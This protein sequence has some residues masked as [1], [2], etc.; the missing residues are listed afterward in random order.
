VNHPRRDLSLLPFVGLRLLGRLELVSNGRAPTLKAGGAFD[1]GGLILW[2]RALAANASASSNSP[3]GTQRGPGATAA[4]SAQTP[5]NLLGPI[6]PELVTPDVGRPFYRAITTL[7]ALALI[8]EPPSAHN[9]EGGD[10]GPH[11]DRE[12]RFNTL[13]EVGEPVPDPLDG[14][15]PGDL[16]ATPAT[17]FYF[18]ERDVRDALLALAD[19]CVAAKGSPDT[20]VDEILAWLSVSAATP[21]GTNAASMSR[22]ALLDWFPVFPSFRPER[23][24][25]DGC[26][27]RS[28][29]VVHD[30]PDFRTLAGRLPAASGLAVVG[31]AQRAFVV[32]AVLANAPLARL[33]G[34]EYAWK[35]IA[36]STVA[37]MSSPLRVVIGGDD[38]LV[39]E[40]IAGRSPTPCLKGRRTG[41]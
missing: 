11:D 19:R 1:R 8:E 14:R 20:T 22:V 13:L 26:V 41:R 38:V 15:R 4:R 40:G 29:R 21:S 6:R 24:G 7:D 17:R 35:P 28:V 18:V 37:G 16:L 32:K 9:A 30:D 5:R 23:D 27:M 33:L 2:P 3:G 34:G 10:P 25:D 39:R 12:H 36:R 31:E